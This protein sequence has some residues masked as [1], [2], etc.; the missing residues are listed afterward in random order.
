MFTLRPLFPVLLLAL[1]LPAAAQESAPHAAKPAHPAAPAAQSAPAAPG[2]QGASS[3]HAT[4]AAAEAPDAG[5]VR[6]TGPAPLA[7]SPEA[8]KAS[9]PLKTCLVSDEALGG[10]MGAPIPYVFQGRYMEFCCEECKFNVEK[11]PA[12]FLAKLDA[13]VV[14]A[15]RP[16]YP[17]AT[18]VMSNEKL[19][20]NPVEVV[21]GTRLVRF[22]CNDCASDF[23]RGP[24]AALARID[25][26]YIAAQRA[27][28]PLTTCP[29]S[30]ETLEAPV[31]VLYGVQLV[32]FCCKECA[33]EFR[34]NPGKYLP[35]VQAAVAE[36]AAKA[37]AAPQAGQP[38]APATPKQG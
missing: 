8:Q 7:P 35:A 11:E 21:Y 19:G 30:G 5:S 6:P 4:H 20:D 9:Y 25:E 26:A 38:A 34:A 27:S 33:G 18:C 36:Q 3:E 14:A 32:K 29:V 15:Q 2:A 10:A 28:Y 1:A 37:A 22:C 13:A 16:T 12:K 31:E 17:L 23:S 24:D